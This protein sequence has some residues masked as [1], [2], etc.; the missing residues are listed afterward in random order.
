MVFMTF[1]QAQVGAREKFCTVCWGSSKNPAQGIDIEVKARS[2][3]SPPV[4]Y[5]LEKS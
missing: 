3:G 5:F 4:Y 1:H 2:A